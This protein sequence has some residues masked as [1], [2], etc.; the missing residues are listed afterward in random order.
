MGEP[1]EIELKFLCAPGDMDAVLDAAPPGE[2]EVLELV[3][4]YY[5]TPDGALAQAQASFRVRASKGR[6]IQTLKRGKGYS[7]EEHELEVAG[8]GPDLSM[9]VLGS[10]LDARQLQTLGEVSTVRITRR[11]RLVRFGEALIEIAADTGEARAAGRSSP[12]SEVE[13]ELKSGPESALFEL[14]RHL[15]QAAPLHPSTESKSDRGRALRGI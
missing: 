14:A 12:I 15:G 10:L 2:D 11:Q 3:S 9:P 6:L 8:P 7:R 4:T 5:D 13:L 1:R